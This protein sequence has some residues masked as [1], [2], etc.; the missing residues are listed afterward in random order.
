MRF[1]AALISATLLV[2]IVPAFSATSELPKWLEDRRK[3]QLNDAKQI[4][5]FH[6]FQFTDR[7]SESQIGFQHH[8]VEDANKHYKAV[9]YDHGCGVAVADVDGDGRLDIF[10]VSQLGGCELWRN[11]GGG[12]FENITQTA[13]VG[14]VG[15]V[16]VAAAFA[17]IDN[18]GDPD[19]FVTT[20]RGGNALFENDGHGKFHDI[21]QEAGV[22]YVGH[23][24]GIVFFDF[25]NDGLLD[26]YVCNVGRY[27]TETKGTGGYYVAFKDAFKGHLFPDRYEPGLL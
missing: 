2:T 17:D 8:A 27:T 5:A 1:A 13:G 20:V 9:H 12:K 23:S 7:W 3:S 15:R 24:S 10:F 18:D 4:R 22:G 16:G 11:L 14:L 19:L 26:L 21:T 25:D 6:D